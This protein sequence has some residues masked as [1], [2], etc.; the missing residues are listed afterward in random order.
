MALANAFPV[1]SKEDY[2]AFRP[3]LGPNAP[4]AHDEWL[5]IH[6]EQV[7]QTRLNG[8][9]A[10]EIEIQHDEFVEFCRVN[11]HTPNQNALMDFATKKAGWKP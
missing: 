1:I 10:A 11:G 3:V 2:P 8:D 7:E 6:R 5:K 9:E 4:N